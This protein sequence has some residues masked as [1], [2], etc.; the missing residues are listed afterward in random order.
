MRGNTSS[1]M[2]PGPLTA[3][4]E[5]SPPPPPTCRELKVTK[6]GERH[7]VDTDIVR[8][9]FTNGASDACSTRGYPTLTLRDGA[10]RTV[11]HNAEPYTSGAAPELVL[12]PGEFAIVDVRFPQADKAH[13]GCAQGT[14]RIEIISPAATNRVSVD[15][16]HAACPGWSVSSLHQGSS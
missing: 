11:G 1:D 6:A 15:D 4:P 5:T 7:T 2:P 3:T 12:R 16:N 9:K 10:G 8:L 13:G 14:A